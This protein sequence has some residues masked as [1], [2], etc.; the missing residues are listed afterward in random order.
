M[1]G[2]EVVGHVVQKV[3][4]SGKSGPKRDGSMD[5]HIHSQL[6]G[7]AAAMEL[8]LRLWG[9][10]FQKRRTFLAGAKYRL[11]LF[12]AIRHRQEDTST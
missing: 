6:A 11:L 9:K 7:G 12:G 2:G 4:S 5:H 3:K 10:C 1:S 8:S